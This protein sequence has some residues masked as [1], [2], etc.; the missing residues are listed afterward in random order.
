M[1]L[2]DKDA[3]SAEIERQQRKLCILSLS[4]KVELRRDAAIQNG[5]YCSLL[6]FINTLEVK[7]MD[8]ET[9]FVTSIDHFDEKNNYGKWSESDLRQF[10]KHFFELGIAESNKAQKGK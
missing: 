7:E 5:V 8:F 4:N 6:S 10:A 9:A 2:I 3:L 1:E